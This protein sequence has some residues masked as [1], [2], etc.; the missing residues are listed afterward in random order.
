MAA[1]NTNNT[2][3]SGTDRV[4]Y[5]QCS[6]LGYNGSILDD[7]G[8]STSTSNTNTNNPNTNP[9]PTISPRKP[10]VQPIDWFA[11]SQKGKLLLPVTKAYFNRVALSSLKTKINTSTG[12]APSNTPGVSGTSNSNTNTAS[13]T[14]FHYMANCKYMKF[15]QNAMESLQDVSVYVISVCMYICVYMT[16]YVY[17]GV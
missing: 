14:L 2:A 10:L 15:T 9:N 8:G 12:S 5:M 7:V 16:V 6:T 11:L 4:L 17:I 13:V 3:N 1:T